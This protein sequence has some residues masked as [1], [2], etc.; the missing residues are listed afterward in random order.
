MIAAGAFFST[1]IQA[2]IDH[3]KQKNTRQQAFAKTRAKRSA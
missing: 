3:L 1:D 2:V